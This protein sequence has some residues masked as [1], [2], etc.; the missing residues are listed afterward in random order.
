MAYQA[1]GR[2]DREGMTLAELFRRFPDDA[3]AEKWF[4]ERRWGDAPACPHCGSLNVQTG[5]SHK[6][7]PYRCREK[8]CAKRFS[9]KTGTVM[10]SSNLGYQTWA[11]AIY[12]MLTS[13]KGVS[14]MKLHRDLGISQKSAWHLAHRIRKAFEAN[15]MGG[16]MMGPVEVDESYV[17]G[18][19]RNKHRRKRLGVGGGTGGK[20][21]V[22]GVKDRLTNQVAA[23]PVPDVAKRTLLAHVH[24]HA[25][26]SAMIYS[27]EARAYAGLIRH[28][29][30]SHGVGEYVRGQVHINGMESFWAMLKRGYHGVYHKMSPK[31]LERYV[32]E[33]SGRHNI[34]W[35]DTLWQ[36]EFVARRMFGKRLR[37]ADLTE[38]TGLPS[39]A[40]G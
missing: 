11:I 37:Y 7:M 21:A 18:R 23:K 35:A 33:F 28:E 3:V 36:M 10:Q 8:A 13:L 30:V 4:A 15:V 27:D 19:E 31:H 26:P 34:R 5:A 20:T 24:A 2:A 32:D 40:R 1:P 16:P 39:G 14:S 29:A 9:V 38:P 17:G 22:V 6:T 25:G 12:L